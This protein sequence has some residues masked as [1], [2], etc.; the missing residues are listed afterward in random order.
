[1]LLKIVAPGDIAIYG[2]LCA[3]SSL[4]R[5][6]IKSLI[7][8]NSTFGTFIEQEPYIRDL[9]EAYM[10]SNFK[11]VLELLSRFSVRLC[12]ISYISVSQFP[13][14]DETLHGHPSFTPRP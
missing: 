14:L 12:P 5:R 9:I 11:T 8:E 10:G 7:L 4:K 13:F 3:L 1:M 2:T 6:Q